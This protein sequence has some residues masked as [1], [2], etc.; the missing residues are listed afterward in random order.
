MKP[1]HRRATTQVGGPN[2]TCS[3][4]PPAHPHHVGFL[5]NVSSIPAYLRWIHYLSVFFYAFEA[6]ITNEMTGRTFTFMVGRYEERAKAW[7]IRRWSLHQLSISLISWR[8]M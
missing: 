2:S 7:M 3:R 8:R 6:M 1:L 4:V 5:V